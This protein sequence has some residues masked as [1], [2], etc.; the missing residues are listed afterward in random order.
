MMYTNSPS[1]AA[2]EAFVTYYVKNLHT[3]WSKKVVP[4]IPALQSIV[5]S[6]SFQS[7][8]QALKIAQKW[9]PYAKSLAA[10]SVPLTAQL[11]SIDGGTA[12]FNF[13]STVLSGGSDAKTALVNLESGI[14]S[15]ISS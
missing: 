8:K 3:L 11:A 9:Q 2:S 13:A 4:E 10:Q 15:A 5:N 6:P 1:Q 12:S 7:D 14:K